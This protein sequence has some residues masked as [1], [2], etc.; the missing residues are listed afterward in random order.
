M[1]TG[2]QSTSH[3]RPANAISEVYSTD[4]TGPSERSRPQAESGKGGGTSAWLESVPGAGRGKAYGMSFEKY[5]LQNRLLRAPE[6]SGTRV[7]PSKQEGE[8]MEDDDGQVT[9]IESGSMTSGEDLGNH[10]EV[11]KVYWCPDG[12]SNESSTLLISAKP[13][14][15]GADQPTQ[16]AL[17]A[18]KKATTKR[19]VDSTMLECDETKKGTGHADWATQEHAAPSSQN[20]KPPPGWI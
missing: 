5:E 2:S 9:D 12:D 13:S 3:G 16:E 18:S 15:W 4:H 1:S 10:N 19:R 17:P 11:I 8:Q 7:N 20:N 14:T 6:W